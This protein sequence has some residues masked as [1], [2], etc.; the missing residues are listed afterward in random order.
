MKISLSYLE[1]LISNNVLQVKEL[2]S[3]HYTYEYALHYFNENA[4][5][6]LIELEHEI[7][8]DL[9]CKTIGYFGVE[10]SHNLLVYNLKN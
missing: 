4:V 2:P 9:D 6:G 10:Y 1:D 8:S 7:I 3:G 5:F